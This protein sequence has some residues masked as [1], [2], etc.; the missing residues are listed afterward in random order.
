[1]AR[2]ADIIAIFVTR[3]ESILVSNGYNTDAGNAIYVNENPGLGTDDEAPIPAAVAL[4]TQPDDPG[5]W[6][7]DAL[8]IRLPLEFQAHVTQAVDDPYLLA[9]DLLEDVKRAVERVDEPNGETLLEREART[10]GRKVAGVTFARG[11]TRVIP[12]EP[13]QTTVGLGVTYLI[14][15]KEKWGEP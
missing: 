6:Q 3:L 15:Y 2:R 13:G 7:G 9:E 11:S 5:D 12:R 10:L 14:P 8:L 4:I 1:M